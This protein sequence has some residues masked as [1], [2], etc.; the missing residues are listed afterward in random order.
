MI[1]DSVP[2]M[3]HRRGLIKAFG[4]L[5][6]APAIVRA[7]SL[8]QVRGI[9]APVAPHMMVDYEWDEILQK[10]L[11]ECADEFATNMMKRNALIRHLALSQRLDST[12]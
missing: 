8:M 6:A 11:L 2:K 1:R 10:T 7:D 9:V 5:I 4:A 12:L 3:I